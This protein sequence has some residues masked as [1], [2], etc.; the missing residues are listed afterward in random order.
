MNS[1]TKARGNNVFLAIKYYPMLGP[2]T[3]TWDDLVDDNGAPLHFGI[4]CY[5]NSHASTFRERVKPRDVKA[6]LVLLTYLRLEHHTVEDSMLFD[7]AMLL[8]K[9]SSEG[10]GVHYNLFGKPNRMFAWFVINF[11]SI[12][13]LFDTFIDIA[14]CL[15]LCLSRMFLFL[16]RIWIC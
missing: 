8:I 4:L 5:N 1:Q 11:L 7:S 10:A 14:R 15:L 13:I 2:F 9:D 12:L 3:D 6:A 16:R